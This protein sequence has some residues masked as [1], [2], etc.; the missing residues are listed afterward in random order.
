M[1]EEKSIE[2]FT[3]KFEILNREVNTFIKSKVFDMLKDENHFIK[4]EN[5]FPVDMGSVLGLIIEKDGSINF[6]LLDTEVDEIS[7]VSI[8]FLSTEELTFLADELQL[9]RISLDSIDN[10]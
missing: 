5:E 3:E 1:I 6:V 2:S 4:F 9:G 7:F 10:I 8:D